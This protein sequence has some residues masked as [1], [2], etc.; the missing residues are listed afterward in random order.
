MGSLLTDPVRAH[1]GS[2]YPERPLSLD[3]EGETLEVDRILSRWRTPEG[4]AFRVKVVDGRCFDLIYSEGSDRWSILP[5]T[6]S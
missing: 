3:W 2:Q 1:A 5:L 6:G 4:R